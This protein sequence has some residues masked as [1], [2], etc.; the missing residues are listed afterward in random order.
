MQNPTRPKSQRQSRLR[1]FTFVAVFGFLTL[2][3]IA[4]FTTIPQHIHGY[5]TKSERLLTWSIP[6]LEHVAMRI[7]PMSSRYEMGAK[8]WKHL[9][10][11][12]GHVVH[13]TESDGSI[14][15]HTVAMFHQLRCLEILH[16]AYVDEGS[17]RT[18]SLA[19]HC[20]N[21]LRQTMLCQMDMRTELQGSVFTFNGFDQM[22]Y[23]WEVLYQEAER[24]Y[25]MYAKLVDD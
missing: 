14:T 6:P 11:E 1:E 22:C 5:F 17:H 10:P 16:D 24:N 8:A 4:Y 9:L 20:M 18:S 19:G 7:I 25:K 21:Y 12:G 3:I 2:V 15:S 13:L 23:D